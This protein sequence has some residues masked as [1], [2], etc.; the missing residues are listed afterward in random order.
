VECLLGRELAAGRT[1]HQ[2]KY[3]IGNGRE[4]VVVS[5]RAVAVAVVRRRRR[6]VLL[7]I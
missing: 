5:E 3:R 4:A 6:G 2:C 1:D 7:Y